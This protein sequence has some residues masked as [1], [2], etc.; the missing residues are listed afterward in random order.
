MVITSAFFAVVV[1]D[2]THYHKRAAQLLDQKRFLNAFYLSMLF[3]NVLELSNLSHRGMTFEEDDTLLRSS[4][5][6][7]ISATHTFF[8]MVSCIALPYLLDKQ[9][10]RVANATN[11]YQPVNRNVAQFE[12]ENLKV[13]VDYSPFQQLIR[14]V[15]LGRVITDVAFL[16]YRSS[17]YNTL[18]LLLDA[19]VLSSS[20]K[21]RAIKIERTGQADDQ[22]IDVAYYFN[23]FSPSHPN[24]SV[25]HQK[26]PDIGFCEKHS[27]HLKCLLPSVKEIIEKSDRFK[28][29]VKD[30]TSH[31]PMDF[32]AKRKMIFIDFP[33]D[34]LPNCPTC[35]RMVPHELTILFKKMGLETR[36]NYTDTMPQNS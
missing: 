20:L 5:F 23:M 19:Y 15:A 14:P 10:T 27:F 36:I 28:F 21:K 25:C 26:R 1:H 18:F 17:F 9:V 13:S 7:L 29:T 33:K 16:Y 34:H 24:C 22:R 8:W 11:F 12:E 6:D 3:F 35:N 4:H 30:G 2:A 31:N 32:L